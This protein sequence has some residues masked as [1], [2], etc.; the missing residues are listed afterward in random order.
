MCTL[1]EDIHVPQKCLPE[2]IHYRRGSQ[3]SD[4]QDALFNGRQPSSFLSHSS[5]CAVDFGCVVGVETMHGFNTQ[6]FCH[7]GD[8][9]TIAAECPTC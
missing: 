6:A 9:P 2:D 8:L 7:Q 1:C 4:G 5:G 3:K